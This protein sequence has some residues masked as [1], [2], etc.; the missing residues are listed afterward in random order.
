MA[1][2]VI[3]QLLLVDLNRSK[4]PKKVDNNTYRL[5]KSLSRQRRLDTLIKTAYRRSYSRRGETSG[6]YF[7][8]MKSCLRHID[9]DIYSRQVLGSWLWADVAR[10]S[11]SDESEPSAD[12]ELMEQGWSGKSS[13]ASRWVISITDSE[14]LVSEWPLLGTTLSN[15]CYRTVCEDINQIIE[16]LGTS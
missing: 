10:V 7:S 1:S 12:T 3:P 6:G 13:E 9:N 11:I 5:L 15:E 4:P 14:G 8:W 16:D 2:R